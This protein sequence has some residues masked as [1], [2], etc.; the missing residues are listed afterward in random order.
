MRRRDFITLVGGTAASWPRTTHAQQPNRMRLIGVLMGYVESDPGAQ[1][2]VAVFRSALSKLGWREGSNLQIE[3]RWG[4]GDADKARTFA[5]ELVDLRPDVILSHTSAPTRAL[6]GETRTIPIVFVTVGD[7]TASGLVANFARPGG[8]ITG[9]TVDDPVVGGK[10]VELL[11]EIAPGTVHMA[12]LWNPPTGPPLQ[13]YMPFMQAAASSFAVEVSSA[14]V[15][16][17]DEIEGVIAA[18]AGAPGGGLLVFPA[19]FNTVNRELIIALAARYRVPTIYTNSFYVKSGGLIS[20]G[21]DYTEQ[22]R[23]VTAY[24]DRILKGAKPID[25]PVQAP[26]R[27]ELFINLKTAKA[28]G[29]EVPPLMQQRADEVIE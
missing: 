18:Q 9:F 21:T 7:S 25:L 19:S 26:T 14:P 13:L 23:Q 24:I 5:K 17:M 15:H 8:N 1:Y 16:A 11:K 4:G 28:L 29:L 10:W 27:F 20:Y 2:E 3:L 6:A 22:F 12:V